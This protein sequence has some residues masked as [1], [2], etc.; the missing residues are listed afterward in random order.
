MAAVSIVMPLV[1]G[2][3]RAGPGGWRGVIAD[4]CRTIADMRVRA[5]RDRPRMVVSHRDAHHGAQEATDNGAVIA[6][7]HVT[8]D[9]ASTGTQQGTGQFVGCLSGRAAQGDQ[10]GHE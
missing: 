8:D 2:M 7:D 9:R 5:N 1:M 6:T 4:R 3:A 10:A